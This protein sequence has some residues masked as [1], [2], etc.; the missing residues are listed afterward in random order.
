MAVKIQMF[1]RGQRPPWGVSMADIVF[2]YYQNFGLT[3]F[4]AIFLS[5]NAET[6]GPVRS[7]R[8]LDIDLVNMYRSIFAFG[9]AEQRTYSR[10]FNQAFYTRLIVEGN[11]NCPPMC[12]LEPNTNNYL[13]ANTAALGE[14][15]VKQG[16]DNVR[17]NLDGMRFDAAVPANG[18][19]GLQVF[20]RHS[21]SAYNHWDY[22]PA[23]GRYLRFQDTQEA[24]DQASEGYEPLVDRLTNQQIATENVVL[25]VVGH[26]YA[27]GTRPARTK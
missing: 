21:I 22:D 3:R 16:V 25:I 15:A 7:A 14:R 9:N 20:T 23:S 27:F 17:Q 11:A 1:P 19:P 26:R 6:V 10:L 12:R 24:N 13:V 8:L 5:Q 2:D 4:H 18:Q